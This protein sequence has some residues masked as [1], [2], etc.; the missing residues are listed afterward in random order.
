MKHK[1]L[2][3][4]ISLSMLLNVSCFTVHAK[5]PTVIV[6][7]QELR[8]DVSPQIINDRTMVPMRSIFEALGYSVNWNEQTQ[9]ITATGSD[10][11]IINVG[12]NT[13]YKND[14]AYT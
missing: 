13:F 3:I 7:G 14:V 10:K 9:K 11:I 6:N 8:S 1:T 12:S 5:E 4:F 2:S